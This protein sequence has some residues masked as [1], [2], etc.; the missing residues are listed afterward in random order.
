MAEKLRALGL[1]RPAGWLYDVANDGRVWKHHDGEREIVSDE[2]LARE[3]GYLYFIDREG[4]LA[5]LP[6]PARRCPN[7]NAPFPDSSRTC[8]ACAAG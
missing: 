4:D 8:A 7:C 2:P 1:P 3:P 6:D 5:R